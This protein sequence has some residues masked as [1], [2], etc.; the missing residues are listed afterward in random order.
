MR[1]SCLCEAS[2]PAGARNHLAIYIPEKMYYSE[3]FYQRMKLQLPIKSNN[4]KKGP[5]SLGSAA[6]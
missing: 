3:L 2:L 5:S 6:G 4:Y 1:G